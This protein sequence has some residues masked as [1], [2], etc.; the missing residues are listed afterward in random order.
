MK[1]NIIGKNLKHLRK[2][3]Y[4][5][6]QELCYRMNEFDINI[7]RCAYEAYENNRN[8]PNIDMIKQFCEF[9]RLSMEELC[10]LQLK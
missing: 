1:K 10:F 5:S 7:T 2:G 4:L 3:L 8:E 6:Q 9:F